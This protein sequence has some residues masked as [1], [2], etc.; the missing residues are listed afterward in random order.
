MLLLFISELAF[1]RT[2][3]VENHLLVDGSQADREFDISLDISFPALQCK[4][5]QK[6]V[7]G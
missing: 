2:T 1:W 4:G 6:L 5:A 3:R 7:G